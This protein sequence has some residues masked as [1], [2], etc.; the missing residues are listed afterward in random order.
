MELVLSTI[1]AYASDGSVETT[2]SPLPSARKP[3]GT[4]AIKNIFSTKT[5]LSL[6]VVS[7]KYLISHL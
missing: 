7:D 4:K 3:T 6:F 1:I 2:K 5:I